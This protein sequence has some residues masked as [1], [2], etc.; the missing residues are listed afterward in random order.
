MSTTL[1]LWHCP[2]KKHAWRAVASATTSQEL[3]NQ[4]RGNG[5]YITSEG[6]THPDDRRKPR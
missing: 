6:D 2:N 3:T 5:E 1:T 4:M